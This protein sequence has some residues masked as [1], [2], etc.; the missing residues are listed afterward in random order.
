M[1][2]I[3]APTYVKPA[4]PYAFARCECDHL[5]YADDVP[6]D[7]CRFTAVGLCGCSIHWAPLDDLARRG[8]GA[9]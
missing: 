1:T 7:P 9:A 5:V 6:G 8:D 3:D 4:D 2:R